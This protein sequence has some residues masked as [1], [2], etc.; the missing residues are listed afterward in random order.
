MARITVTDPINGPVNGSGTINQ[1][2]VNL[3]PSGGT[4]F[5]VLGQNF[6][7]DGEAVTVTYGQTASAFTATGCARYPLSSHTTL[8]CVTAPGAGQG[9]PL[10]VSVGGQSSTPTNGNVTAGLG[11]SYAAP[12]IT[13]VRGVSGSLSL[14]YTDGGEQLTITGTGFGSVSTPSTDIIVHYGLQSGVWLFTATGCTVTSGG[15]GVNTIHCLTAPGTGANHYFQVVLAGMPSAIF[16]ATGVSYAAPEIASFSGPG[17]AATDTNGGQVIV[18]SGWNMGPL[19]G[20]YSSVIDVRYSARIDGKGA[21]NV[22]GAAGLV[23]SFQARSCAVSVAHTTITCLT[24]PGAGAALSWTVTIDG[25]ASTSP[26]TSYCEPQVANIT[27]IDPGT[28]TSLVPHLSY[29]VAIRGRCFGPPAY[30]PP[31]A[32]ASVTPRSLVDSVSFGPT[33]S[34]YA[35]TPVTTLAAFNA[36]YT[37]GRLVFY[38]VSDSEIRAVIG[39]A[40]TANNYFSIVV[41]GQVSSATTP[42]FSFRTPQVVRLAPA[43]APVSG[44]ATTVTIIGR[45]LP[46]LDA[47][48][49]LAI[50][51][52]NGAFTLTLPARAPPTTLSGVNAITNVDGTQNVS[53]ILPPWYMGANI[54]VKVISTRSIDGGGAIVAA[55]N[56]SATSAFSYAN[57]T[58]TSVG[59]TPSAFLP[60]N[61]TPTGTLWPCPWAPNDATWRCDGSL[62]QLYTLTVS[63]TNLG[64]PSA[65]VPQPDGVTRILESRRPAL[66]SPYSAANVWV[67]DWTNTRIVAY[68]Y[69]PQGYIQVRLAGTGW[70]AVPTSQTANTAYSLYGN[71]VPQV[72]SITGNNQNSTA[73]CSASNIAARVCNPLHMVLN[74]LNQ[75]VALSVR[76]LGAVT[77]ECPLVT[78]DG[79]PITDLRAQV[80]QPGLA[81]GRWDVYCAVP[82][83]SGQFNSIYLNI[84]NGLAPP[85]PWIWTGSYVT[86]PPPS[87]MSFSVMTSPGVW[88]PWTPIDANGS[89]L[90]WVNTTGSR[91]RLQGRALG[92]NSQYV[93]CADGVVYGGAWGSD[94]IDCSPR[95]ANNVSSQSCVEFPVPAGEGTG[96][97][98]PENLARGFRLT[99]YFGSTAPETLGIRYYPPVVTSVTLDVPAQWATSGATV[100]IHGYNFGQPS[101]TWRDAGQSARWVS[102]RFGRSIDGAGSLLNCLNE[103]RL[104]HTEITCVLPPGAGAGLSAIVSAADQSGPYSAPTLDYEPP[105]LMEVWAVVAAPPFPRPTPLPALNLTLPPP[106]SGSV[107]V[108]PAPVRVGNET[109]SV[110][111]GLDDPDGS[112]SASRVTGG[113]VTSGRTLAV[114]APGEGDAWASTL[115]TLIGSGFG[116]APTSDGS[117]VCVLLVAP[118]LSA[119][120]RVPVCNGVVDYLTEGEVPFAR[121]VSWSDTRIV[122]SLP[123][124]TGSRTI[125]LNLRGARLVNL[126]A[127]HLINA[128]ASSTVTRAAVVFD[129]PTVAGVTPL[130]RVDPDGS[131]Y[132][133]IVGSGFGWS[134][135]F[136]PGVAYD[137]RSVPAASGHA[138]PVTPSIVHLDGPGADRCLADAFDIDG[139]TP[140][141]L[142]SGCI[143]TP[144]VIA[145]HTPHQMVV[146]IPPGVSAGHIVSVRVVEM[147]ASRE[148]ITAGNR[149]T[150]Y[151]SGSN[152]GP[153]VMSYAPPVISKLNQNLARVT[154]PGVVDKE[155]PLIISGTGF[156]S[157][158]LLPPLTGVDATLRVDVGGTPCKNP[159]RDINDATGELRILCTLDVDATPVGVYNVRLTVGNQVSNDVTGVAEYIVACDAGHYGKPG[160]L[161][162]PCP[163]GGVCLGYDS[164]RN[165][166]ARFLYP[167][168]KIGWFDLGAG[169][170]YANSAN[171]RTAPWLPAPDMAAACPASVKAANGNNRSACVVPC[172]PAEACL[173]ANMCAEGYTSYAPD[174]R[175]ASCADGFYRRYSRCERCPPAAS[176][177]F[178]GYIIVVALAAALAYWLAKSGAGGY[179]PL[180]AVALDYVQVLGVMQYTCVQWP[181]ELRELFH[182]MSAFF[183][184]VDIVAAECSLGSSVHYAEK[185]AFVMLLPITFGALLAIIQGCITTYRLTVMKRRDK[186]GA[187]L[188]TLLS[189]QLLVMY[190]LYIYV[191]RVLLDPLSCVPPTPQLAPGEVNPDV[192]RYFLP[193][194]APCDNYGALQ[195]PSLWMGAAAIA[196][197]L[198]YICAYPAAVGAWLWK[199]K[200][201][202]MQDQLLRAKGTGNDRLTNPHALG[203]RKRW[204]RLYHQFKPDFFYWILMILGRKASIVIV[205]VIFN[206]NASYQLASI[207]IILVVSYGLQATCSP[208]MSPGDHENVIRDHL[209][210]SYTS[211][212]HARLRETLAG[213]ESRGKKASR[214]NLMDYNGRIDRSALLSVLGS[215]L[216]N[217]NTVECVTLFSLIIVA[218]TGLMFQSQS[219]DVYG[220][221][222]TASLA[223]ANTIIVMVALTLT[224]V[225][226]VLGTDVVLNMTARQREAALLQK[227]RSSKNLGRK[228]VDGAGSPIGKAMSSRELAAMTAVDT[229]FNPLHAKGAAAAAAAAGGAGDK[230]AALA[231][232]TGGG[233]MAD[234]SAARSVLDALAASPEPPTRD[235]WRAY[236]SA[237]SALTSQVDALSAE[238]ARMRLELEQARSLAGSRASVGVSGSSSSS[239]VSS[240]SDSSFSE[241]GGEMRNPLAAATRSSY[242]PTA[243]AGYNSVRRL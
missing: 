127:P 28:V 209:A 71:L 139:T 34:T 113:P 166:T 8:R 223:T 116:P 81:S 186:K 129:P 237:S 24:A 97:Q 17:A 74:N 112:G 183:L 169:G 104:S 152:S 60:A 114:T 125:D 192:N 27:M 219:L 228:G 6:G 121:I 65:L 190:A 231:A 202:I 79:Q 63:G 85:Q 11:L 137:P 19:P 146:R 128:V 155:F 7:P 122:F 102:V 205:Q 90:A 50:Q 140:H 25:V 73:G 23:L 214:K 53:F 3:N 242:G 70:D 82:P 194:F 134:S 144:G 75:T 232:A 162:A 168:A 83:G 66:G 2:A 238:I 174:Y 51:F 151:S 193:E 78:S 101:A 225:A 222:K 188:S 138:L 241:G 234:V 45:D 120:P 107:L 47:T 15:P 203:F 199:N 164:T 148:D 123:R 16:R 61:S 5:Y 109:V 76:I 191:T 170:W 91:M 147:S 233:E 220:G 158:A 171:A 44:D 172:M 18:L 239:N 150:V 163:V 105:Q 40:S 157:P 69:I 43:T 221:S 41:A 227:R 117:G 143:A 10:T 185:W 179:V 212:L 173:A 243:M 42:R 159:V 98:Y 195:G 111:P 32:N 189:T 39:P 12:T 89:T 142:T 87:L 178:I 141:P 52:G 216:F 4:T 96:A 67:Q 20:A 92:G 108:P 9:L 135:F 229:S 161:C 149:T 57:P 115:V 206:R 154:S 197:I 31:G 156:G 56:V 84:T 176:G 132:V 165:G 131:T 177:L 21:T 184:N 204:G 29:R 106:A 68:S 46:F 215:Y 200:E 167:S 22:T 99:A 35:L 181:V 26:T 217:Y 103:V 208:Y 54:G 49:E 80:L 124:G 201:L 226:V 213:I 38:H 136:P 180:A 33:G 95:D 62:G 94:I 133:S 210:A 230:A 119:A 36:A 118:P 86:Y 93:Q 14:G 211:A 48:N 13:S 55:S 224:Y 1:T 187:G 88:G 110:P 196:G 207:V 126:T 182:V 175:C 130:D 145:L 30:L 100:R 37:S 58:I 236:T 77:Q 153:Y 64:R 59:I 160:E 72:L 240:N 235:M 198:F 218:I